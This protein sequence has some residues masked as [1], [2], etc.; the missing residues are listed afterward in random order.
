MALDDLRARAQERLKALE[1]TPNEGRD[2]FQQDALAFF[3]R[4][5]EP[6]LYRRREDPSRK[7][8]EVLLLEAETLLARSWRLGAAVEVFTQAI[9]AHGVALE[10]MAKGRVEHAESAWQDALVHERRATAPLRLWRRSDEQAAPVYEPGTGASRFD[11]RP[12]ANVEAT[13]VCPRCRKV[14]KFKLSSRVASH[15]LRCPGCQQPF[16]AYVGELRALELEPLGKQRRRY[17]FRVEDLSGVQTRVE[18]DDA[19]PAE[20]AASKRDLL[21]F[22]YV[23]D[24]LRGVLNLNTSKLLWITGPGACFV[25]TVAFGEGAYELQALRSFRDR[26]LR[27][28]PAGRRFITLYYRHGPALAGQV[29]RRPRLR[30]VVRRGLRAAVPWLERFNR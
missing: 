21:A 17:R 11:P 20:L 30:E 25:A 12:E 23:S 14:N 7:Q 15:E 27:R 9:E 10:E 16:T 24:E 4:V 1:P 13:L 22:L 6:P 3:S 5:P 18:F 29:M 26:V 19:T 8:A 28:S 2:V